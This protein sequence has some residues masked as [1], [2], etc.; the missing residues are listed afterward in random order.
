MT[1][2]IRDAWDDP[3]RPWPSV[4][5]VET[6][7]R[8]QANCLACLNDKV[9]R[10]RV[11]MD[12][13]TF[14]AVADKVKARGVKI[15]A[16]FCFGDPLLDPGIEEK[17]GYAKS[18]GVLNSYVGLNTNCDALTED[19]FDGI[20]R[21]VPNIVLSFFAVGA[22]F[23]RLTGGLSWG[24][25]YGNARR[26]IAHRDKHRPSYKI[27]VS[28]NKVAGHDLDAVKAAFDGCKVTFVQDAELRYDGGRRVD[29]V[30]DRRRMFPS[31]RCDGHKGA[32]QV[33]PDG[34]AEFC[35]YDIIGTATGGE[36][37]FGHFLDDDW[38][39]LERK[40]RA[41][42]RAGSTLCAR[43]DYWSGCRS[44]FGAGP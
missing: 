1:D 19:R 12:A 31:W 33:K 42:W 24:K 39:T 36:T 16:M 9:R 11:T 20:L 4:V 25:C 5:Y 22:E 35:A 14:A 38:P 6:T 10:R 17:Y 8:C 34:G 37:R 3:S 23:E 13:A 26:F 29:G 43:C 32:L 15:G 41:A 40:F 21:N 27:E 18:I 30:L 28:V 44:E 2:T 7:N